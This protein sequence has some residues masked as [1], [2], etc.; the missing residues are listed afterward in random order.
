MGAVN[1]TEKFIKNNPPTV[2]EINNIK[3][4]LK[5]TFEELMERIP[6]GTEAVAV[7][8]TP[9]SLSAMMQGLKTYEENKVEGSPL[10]INELDEMV[11]NLSSLTS[12]EILEQYGDVVK[13]RE[14]VITA[15]SVI[16]RIIAEIL[17][18][19]KYTV[20]G[21]G[22]RYGTVVEYLESYGENR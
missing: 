22:I 9:T 3:E 17:Q 5:N 12:Q 19:K 1:T 4:K 10:F 6:A 8:G 15:G 18:V 7:A 21:R 20:S 2:G 16:L 13:G 11:R 14:D